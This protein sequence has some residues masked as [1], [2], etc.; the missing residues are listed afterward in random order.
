MSFSSNKYDDMASL[1]D[2]E[3]A[4]R[5]TTAKANFQ[6]L[7]RLLMCGGL[8]LLR[9]TFDSIHS[10]A[11]LP[12]RLS[13]PAIRTQLRGARLTQPQWSALYPSPGPGCSKPRLN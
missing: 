13:D 10:P 12:L 8:G 7:T 6:R 1:A 3:D 11:D 4:L 2:A 5:S 9:E